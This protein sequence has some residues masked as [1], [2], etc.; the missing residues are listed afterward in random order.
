MVNK[1]LII[2]AAVTVWL[3]S[4]CSAVHAEQGIEW[5]PN[6]F[7]APSD[8][9]TLAR[10]GHFRLP[11]PTE[12][13]PAR[14]VLIQDNRFGE[15]LTVEVGPSS[16]EQL[17]PP[18]PV[19][20]A[21][22]PVF[23][24]PVPANVEPAP[25]PAPEGPHFDDTLSSYTFISA[26]GRKGFGIQTFQATD[27]W[28][29]LWTDPEW[30][31]HDS[32]WRFDLDYALHWWEGPTSPD[33]PPRLYDLYFNILL[34]QRW[35]EWFTT[36][37]GIAPGLSGDFRVTPPDMWRMRGRAIGLLSLVEEC[38]AVGG[39]TY[40]DRN[41]VKALPVAG[42]VWQP[43]CDLNLRL[44]FPY[45]KLAYRVGEKSD[46]HFWVY[47]TGEY[48]GGAWDFKSDSGASD[49]VEYDDIRVML[50]LECHHL[51]SHT[52]LVEVGYVFARRLR[53][54]SFTPE[55]EPSDT[56]MARV[57]WTY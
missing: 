42:L 47:L 2:I 31:C 14:L 5:A 18:T 44:V 49:S 21:P 39:F 3:C 8:W 48:G 53:Y 55:F 15:H 16:A 36:E 54:Q 22:A 30:R 4:L 40:L 50:G 38:Q 19:E 52:G 23:T 25:S 6:V 28:V 37:V 1:T 20:G 9:T 35:G 57:G 46:Y 12:P 33:A 45:P 43:N 11:E 56:V 24:D 17:K 32:E 7:R 26:G 10:S 41:K 27:R 13:I 29:D 34:H 51:E